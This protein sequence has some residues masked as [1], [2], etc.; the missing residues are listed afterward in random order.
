M[1]KLVGRAVW[2]A[3][4][5]LVLV[6]ALGAPAPA[7]AQSAPLASQL[8]AGVNRVRA[9]AGLPALAETADL[10]AVALE[11]SADMAS[12]NYFSHVTPE[13]R[14]VFAMLAERGIA[15]QAAGENLA[16]NT[17]DEATASSVALQSFLN[18]PPHRANL[19]NPSF[20]QIGIGVS[21]DGRR[22]YFTL[23]FIG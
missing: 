15:Y 4:G 7:R 22:I 21:S 23:V 19:L 2:L 12:R 20:T 16:W 9:E 18:S 1:P 10:D 14:T 13:G 6:A 11:R 5:V 17:A 3:L 8:V